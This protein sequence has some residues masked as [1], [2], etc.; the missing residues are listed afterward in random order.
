MNKGYGLFIGLAMS[1]AFAG[2]LSAFQHHSEKGLWIE[3]KEDGKLKSTL[4]V[5]EN[6]AWM[7]VKSKDTK[8]NFSKE[9]KHNIITKKMLRAVL[10]GDE[11]SITA[12]DPDRD[13]EV[14]IYTKDLD[15]PGEKGGNS[16]LVLETYKGGRKTF[17]IALPDIEVESKGDDDSDD[18]VTHS[19]GW[20]AL[21][22]FLAKSG[23]ALYVNEEKDDSEVWLYVE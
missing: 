21:L 18:L 20:K 11:K 4:A 6:I 15:V 10:E 14:T 12:K 16:R 3:T 23:G 2:S 13:Q 9:G 8:I 5:T 7:V 19:F 22:P 17:S 1:I